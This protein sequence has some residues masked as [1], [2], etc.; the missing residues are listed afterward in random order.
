MTSKAAA[1][2]GVPTTATS[3]TTTTVSDTQFMDETLSAIQAHYGEATIRARLTEYAARFVRLAS[4]YE[5]E[6]FGH[7]SVDFASRAFSSRVQGVRALG[8]GLLFVDEQ[9]RA[10]ELAANAGRV[11]GW[12]GTPSYGA[13][14]RAFARQVQ[15]RRR[16]R[17]PQGVGGDDSAQG[18]WAYEHED[19]DD[20]DDDLF[21]LAH[22]IHRLRSG[23]S[24]PTGEVLAI[25]DALNGYLALSGSRRRGHTKRQQQQQRRMLR[26]LAHLPGYTGG[27]MPLAHGLL[28]HNSA[29]R[30]SALELMDKLAN[31]TTG[32]KIT[33]ALN[34]FQRAAYDRLVRERA[35]NQ[36]QAMTATQA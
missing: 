36:Q 26:L 8:S 35:A 6:T 21:D 3:S 17:A 9:S 11:E 2:D 25:Y 24:V 27:V 13:R 4:T 12:R 7:S 32:R 28:H 34:A 19:D 18:E 16:S 22:Q 23:K 33:L 20:D 31:D 14:Q 10:R 15:C 1:L 30:A 29:V 5:Q